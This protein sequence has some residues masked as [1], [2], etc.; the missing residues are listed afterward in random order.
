MNNSRNKNKNSYNNSYNNNNGNGNGIRSRLE[1]LTNSLSSG[2]KS[3]TNSVK[4]SVDN[5]KESTTT[6]SN[7]SALSSFGSIFSGVRNNASSFAQKNVMIAKV[8]FI[9]FLVIIFGLLLRLGMYLISRFSSH[10]KNPIIVNGMIVTNKETKFY[11]NPNQFEPKPIVRSVNEDQGMEFTWATWFWI[12]DLDNADKNNYKKIFSKGSTVN[13]SDDFLMNSPGLYL[14]PNT[15]ELHVV[16][17]TFYQDKD[18]TGNPYETIKIDNIPIKKWVN[19][20]IRVQNN[21][22][23]VYLNGTLVKRKNM[24][25]VPKQNYGD[26]FVGHNSTGMNGYLSSLRYFNYGIDVSKIQDI[27]ETGPNLKMVD[28]DYT[29]TQPPYLSLRWYFN[30]S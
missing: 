26:I 29:D 23:D 20:I 27:M 22:V 28:S 5:I 12:N 13:D 17:N 30:Q 14:A 19:V 9:L 4:K 3:T 18:T 2:I 7:S 25:K 16:L 15:N 21:T 1:K 8:I 11:V 24:D 10:S 6:T